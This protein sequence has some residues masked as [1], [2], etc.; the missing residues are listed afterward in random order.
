M[1]HHSEQLNR[2]SDLE[3]YNNKFTIFDH[4]TSYFIVK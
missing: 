2:Q 1:F 4:K 3:N